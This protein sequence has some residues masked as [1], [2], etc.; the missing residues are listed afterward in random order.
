VK[1]PKPL[2]KFAQKLGASVENALEIAR[3][4]RLAPDYGAPYEIVDRGPIH[5]VRRYVAP[6]EDGIP[7]LLVPPLMVT[8]E[9]YDVAPDVS[10]IGALLPRGIA[11]FV[12]DFG[13]PERQEGGMERTLDDHVLAVDAAIDRVRALTGRDVHL[14]G[15]SQGGMF[16]YQA[17]AYRR[18]RGVASAITFGSPVDIHRGLPGVHSSAVGAMVR[19]VEPG[20]KRVLDRIEGLPGELTSTVFKVISTRKEI[21]QRLDF[22]K[23]LHDKNALVRREARRRFLGGEGFVA[24]PGPAFRDFFDQFIVNNRMLS[25]G[26][27]IQGRSITLADITCPVLCFVGTEDD[28]ARAP[29]VR[30]IER[31][32]PRA[33]VS[34]V[35]IKAGHFGLVVG[36]RAIG[37]T[38]PAVADWLAYREGLAE[39]PILLDREA[40]AAAEGERARDEEPEGAGFDVDVELDLFLDSIAGAAKSAMRRMGHLTASATDAIDGFRYQEPRLRRL[41]TIVGSTRISAS[42]SLAERARTTPSATFFLFEDRAFSYADADARVTNV[43]KGLYACGVRPGDRVGVV[44]GSRPSF[45]SMVTALGRLGAIPVVAPPDALGPALSRAFAEADARLVVTDPPRAVACRDEV[46]LRVLVLGGGARRALVEGVVDMEAIDPATVTLPSDLELDAGRARDLAMVLLRPDDRGGLRAAHVTN[47]RWAL[48]ALGAAAACTLKPEDTVYCAIPLHHPT[49]ILVAVG[50]ALEGGARLALGRPFSPATFYEEARRYGATVVF[51]AG[52]MLR[53]LVTDAGTEP[54]RALP[55]R[56]FAGSGMRP[57]LARRIDERFKI[58]VLEFYASTTARVILASA[59]AKKRGSLGRP[60]PGSAV[61][62]V[63]R[64]DRTTGAPIRDERGH[65]V[66]VDVDEPGLLIAAADADESATSPSRHLV[67]DAFAKND[68]WFLTSDVVRRDA[69]GDYW[70]VDGLRGLVRV[71]DEVVSTR[72]V[73]DHLYALDEISIASVQVDEGRLVATVVARDELDGERLSRALA[74]L[75]KHAR[76]VEIAVVDDI[77]MTDGFRPRKRLLASI[78]LASA[79]ARWVLSTAVEDGPR[80]ERAAG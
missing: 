53:A 41:E 50:S 5:R 54:S 69:E 73:E 61:I 79:R 62:A 13:A 20:V 32:A 23:K 26:F 40:L 12:V 15:Y 58:N 27:V 11:P 29:S 30:A 6:R 42:R 16:V 38:W 19:A 33:E 80:Y 48:S 63:V 75:P 10:A 71:G 67:A 57:D 35:E 46:R 34:I 36:S 45:L 1:L 7:L 76:P 24:W 21:E 31:A 52:E 66:R 55:V 17:V 65:F 51:Y 68:R 72:R 43:A 64:A 78:E 37:R 56:L 2:R 60:L 77:P 47:H 39:R 28:I 9:V 3:F 70:L 25:G 49:S 44:M 4:G 18:S 8:S 59:S 22:V 14:A 74:E